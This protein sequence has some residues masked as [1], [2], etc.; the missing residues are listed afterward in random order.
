ML[1]SALVLIGLLFTQSPPGT[2]QRT[3]ADLERLAE[4]M[5]AALR[6]KDADRVL[7]YYAPPPDFVHIDNGTPIPWPQLQ[8]GVR[9]F[10]KSVRVNDLYWKGK[11]NVLLVSDTTAVIHG[12]HTAS[13]IAGDR[14]PLK[15]HSGYWTGVF[16]RT[17]DGW[18]I[19]HSHSSD[20]EPH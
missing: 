6:A 2:G 12:W 4:E 18:R 17:A 9:T 13:G 16:R 3:V 7:A 19:V 15:S 8:A 10:L 20:A 1:S 11:P 14:T 5:L